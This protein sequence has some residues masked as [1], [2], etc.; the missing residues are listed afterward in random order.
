M[1]IV[2]GAGL[3]GAVIARLIAEELN[4]QVLVYEKRDTAGG[5]CYDYKNEDNI[6]IHKYGSHIFHTKN[7]EVWNFV[8]RFTEF[9]DYVHKVYAH[10]NGKE[11]IIP[12]NLSSIYELFPEDKAKI[13]E[14]KLLKTFEFNTKV[15]ILEFQKQDDEDLK[16]LADFVYKNVFEG[17]TMKQWGL[18]PEEIDK[19][20]TAR[21]PVLIGRDDR[22]FYDKFQGIPVEGYTKLI[23]NIL[24]HPNIKVEYNKSL[25]EDFSLADLN[26][27]KIFCTSSI[28]EAFNYQFGELPYRSV[29]FEYEKYD[30]EFYQLNSVVNYPNDN[31]FTRI[32]EYKYYLNDKSDKTVIAKEYS[33]K[34]ERGKNER[35]YPIKNEDNQNI[36]IKYLEEAKKLKNVYFLGRLGGYAY[37]DMDKA[38]ESALNLFKEIK[39]CPKLVL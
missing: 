24:D 4:E 20:V 38:V 12:F 37:Y 36:Y 7:E 15:P 10:I 9:N 17:Y 13:L 31:D 34:F 22:Y 16:S 18:R 8:N 25:G 11:V 28:D 6:F 5:N 19:S 32:H 2:I 39:N 27:D 30:K 23:E 33:Q 3:S 29:R 35:F 21:V 1:N 26:A 14:E